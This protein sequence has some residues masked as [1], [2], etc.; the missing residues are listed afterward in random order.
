MRDPV[1]GFREMVL[2]C[3]SVWNSFAYFLDEYAYIEDKETGHPVLFKLWE[4][5][6]RIL[7]DIVNAILLVILKARQLGLTWLCAAYALWFTM[8]R[9]MKQVIVISAKGDWA[10]EFLDR[11]YFILRK[12]PKWM[13]PR[14]IKDTSE[15]LRFQHEDGLTSEIKSLTTTE[16]GAQS[17][18][19]DVLILDETCWN[20]YVRQIYGASKPGIDAAGGRIIVISNSIK[21]AP[22][23]SWTRQIFTDAVK[24]LNGFKYIFM[25]WQDRPGRPPNFR[26][27]QVKSGMDEEDVI[28]HYP[29]TWQEAVS[30]ISGSFFGKTLARHEKTVTKGIKG[31]LFKGPDGDLMFENDKKGI[32]EVWRW[33]YYILEDWNGFYWENRYAIGSDVSEGLGKSNSA[34][35]VIDRRYDEIVAKVH[36]KRIDADDWGKILFKLSLYYCS[37]M[38]VG[39][40]QYEKEPALICVER[41]GAGI[42]TIKRLEKLSANQYIEEIPGKLGNPVTK[43]IGWNETQQGLW[44]LCGDLKTWFKSTKGGFYDAQ[45]LE[46]ASHTIR[47]EGRRHIGPEDETKLWDCV[48]GAG[49]TIQASKFMEG[50]PK[51]LVPGPEGWRR[52]IKE[53]RL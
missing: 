43:R 24:A 31:N 41:T 38:E 2:E 17:K 22:G 37:S 51:E 4:S 10:I 47:H 19:P 25:P 29:E 34:A 9:P 53:D 46:E 21:T 3:Q 20:P 50:S 5:Q 27:L 39:Y 28:E 12:L 1:N 44:D 35:Y 32:I 14:V 16:A 52:R 33:P 7:P 36:S 18:T 26:K 15:V 11:V 48:V 42:T 6:K 49:C 23:W 13:Y 8:T 30:A 45:L 40:N